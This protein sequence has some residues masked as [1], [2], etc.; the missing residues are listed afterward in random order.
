MKLQKTFK[1][2]ADRD[3]AFIIP[4]GNQ[5]DHLIWAGARKLANRCGLTYRDIPMKRGHKPRINIDPDEIIYLNGGGGFNTWWNWTPKLLNRLVKQYPEN[6]IIVGPSTVALQRWYLDKWLPVSDRVIFYAR[7]RT[8]FNFLEEHYNL[9]LHL[10]QDTALHL[11]YGD[12]EFKQVVEGYRREVHTL[13]GL[14]EDPESTDYIPESINM[15]DYDV[16]V[17]PCQEKNWAQ[18]HLHASRILT[19]RCHSAILGAILGKDTT[20]F[21]GNY[22]KNR[23]I[24]EYSLKKLGVKWV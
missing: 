5:G 20:M 1:K 11:N 17:D 6:T 13:L 7:E 18:L 15:E 10:D 14:R 2:Y 12:A 24:Y 23:S 16:V 8:T 19:N 21:K 22:H 9:N 3:F 4:G